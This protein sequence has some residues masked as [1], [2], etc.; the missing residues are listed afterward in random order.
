M[1]SRTYP[2]LIDLKNLIDDFKSI[3]KGVSLTLENWINKAKD[4]NIS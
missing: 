2:E 1:L 4:F 3:F